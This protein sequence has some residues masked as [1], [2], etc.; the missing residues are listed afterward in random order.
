MVSLGK[1][2][3]VRSSVG[4]IVSIS[5]LFNTC[6]ENSGKIGKIVATA[7]VQYFFN[8]CTKNGGNFV[9]IAPNVKHCFWSGTCCGNIVSTIGAHT[10]VYVNCAAPPTQQWSCDDTTVYTA[11]FIPPHSHWKLVPP[12]TMWLC[13]SGGSEWVNSS[14]LTLD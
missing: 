1:T 5:V 4:N 6:T 9:A 8:S 11:L 7:S 12:T 10:C 13:S 3:C 2:Y 14:R